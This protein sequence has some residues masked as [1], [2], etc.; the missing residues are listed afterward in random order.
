[1]L[2]EG[3]SLVE[4]TRANVGGIH[5]NPRYWASYGLNASDDALVSIDQTRLSDTMF[6]AVVAGG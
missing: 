4:V 6:G 3:E 5:R 2:C 1:M